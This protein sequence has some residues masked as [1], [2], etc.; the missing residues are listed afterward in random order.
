MALQE[1]GT[2][3]A[4][5]LTE[6]GHQQALNA[7]VCHVHADPTSSCKIGMLAPIRP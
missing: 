7:G 4:Y 2:K 3:E 1:E 6:L 5:G